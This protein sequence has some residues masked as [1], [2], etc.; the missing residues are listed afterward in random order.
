MI[1]WLSSLFKAP[2]EAV[3][4]VDPREQLRTLKLRRRELFG[5][6]STRR[7]YGFDNVDG[8]DEQTLKSLDRRISALQLKLDSQG[9]DA[10][11]R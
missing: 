10:Q 9:G 8:D 2:V 1:A 4:A 11:L 7:A 5:L 6:I 3:V